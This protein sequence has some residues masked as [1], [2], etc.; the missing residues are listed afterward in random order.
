MPSLKVVRQSGEQV[1]LT[2]PVGTS[3][4]EAMR[5]GG[6]D[7]IYAMCGGFCSCAT[8]HVYVDAT[9]AEKLPPISDD[10]DELLD[11]LDCRQ[12]NSRLSCQLKLHDGIDGLKLTVAAY[13]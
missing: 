11:S 7:E 9:F 8:C 2:A 4:M 3:V 5:S 6:I 12:P 10:E 13:D 1:V